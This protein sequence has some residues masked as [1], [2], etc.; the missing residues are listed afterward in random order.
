[1]CEDIKWLLM[2][3]TGADRPTRTRCGRVCGLTNFSAQML[4]QCRNLLTSAQKL[5][6]GL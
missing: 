6:I 1:V 5:M 2:V 4:R 3:N